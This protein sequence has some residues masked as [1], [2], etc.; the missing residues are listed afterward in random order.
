MQ[1]WERVECSEGSTLPKQYRRCPERHQ[2]ILQF[3]VI[4]IQSLSW[5][6][7]ALV[8]A[9]KGAPLCQFPAASV[10][11][12]EDS[13]VPWQWPAV[14]TSQKGRVKGGVSKKGSKAKEQF[15]QI[16]PALDLAEV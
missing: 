6:G 15:V 9:T 14:A 12:G 13:P 8:G 11:G 4:W 2:R 10:S 16:C 5:Q 3:S 1:Y 7:W